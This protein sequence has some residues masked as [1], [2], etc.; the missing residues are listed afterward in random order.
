MFRR[1]IFLFL[2][3][4]VLLTVAQ[5]P[6]GYYDDAEGKTG[7]DLR[8]ALYNIIKD[9]D[10]QTYNSLWTHFQSTDKIGSDQV[11]DMY[12][13]RADGSSNYVFHYTD[14]QCGDYSGEGDCYNREHSFPKSWFDDA[15]PMYT[16]LFHLY[17]TDGHV[18]GKRGNLPYGEVGSAD[19]T[20]TNGSKVGNSNVSGYSDKVFE[21]IDA[22]KGDFARS[23]FYMLTRYYP[24]IK[25]WNSD[26][27]S[28]D[29]FSA[30]AR[31]LLL[32]WNSEDPVSDKEKDRNNAVYDIQ[33]NRNPFIDHPEWASDIWG[34]NEGVV[35]I[36]SNTGIRLWC[37][38]NTLYWKL[39][40]NSEGALII[41]NIV[42]QN[43]KTITVKEQQNSSVLNLEDG[44]YIA[45]FTS[46]KEDITVKFIIH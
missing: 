13:V 22:Y 38:N 25:D 27:L 9:H 5:I 6:N 3:F 14:D 34:N 20:S 28:G 31:Q 29:N 36:A 24:R 17:P 32:D 23:Y 35:G 41:Y 11:W 46:E 42:G 44:I 7:S 18:N 15:S 43:I 19:W 45:R 30:W 4:S 33:N 40:E 12:S 26:M 8:S 21:P 1:I 10:E 37:S 39:E 2:Q 16:D